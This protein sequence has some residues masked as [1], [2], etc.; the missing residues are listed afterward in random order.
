MVEPRGGTG[1]R[2]VGG[3]G[4]LEGFQEEIVSKWR[5]ER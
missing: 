3:W 4:V 5:P 1:P 2:W